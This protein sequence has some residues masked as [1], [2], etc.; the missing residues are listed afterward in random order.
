MTL[1][2]SESHLAVLAR[3]GFKVRYLVEAASTNAEN[4]KLER[5]QVGPFGKQQTMKH[6][7]LVTTTFLKGAF[8][9]KDGDVQYP[10]Q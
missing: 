6:G 4:W 10:L 8:P 1:E 5:S 3:Y 7:Q 9:M 2:S